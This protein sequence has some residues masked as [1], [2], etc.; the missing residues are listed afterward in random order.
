MR[1][2]VCFFGFGLGVSRAYSRTICTPLTPKTMSDTP[3]QPETKPEHFSSELSISP[4]VRA[5]PHAVVIPI[6]LYRGEPPVHIMPRAESK[7]RE[8]L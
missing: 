5:M 1:L 8:R 6:A 7:P 4:C 2:L 3:M